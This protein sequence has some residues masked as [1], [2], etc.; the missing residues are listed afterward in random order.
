MFLFVNVVKVKRK[1][2]KVE[3]C[4]LHLEV[5]RKIRKVMVIFLQSLQNKPKGA[6][7][8]GGVGSRKK[9]AKVS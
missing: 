3:G 1:I 4:E 6:K 8:V 7:G 9:K 5:K 2:G